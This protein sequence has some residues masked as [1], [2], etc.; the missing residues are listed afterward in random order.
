MK[1]ASDESI[2]KME[3]NLDVLKSLWS[4]YVVKMYAYLRTDQHMYLY[5]DYCEA[6]TLLGYMKDK[7]D[8]LSEN[9]TVR[10]ELLSSLSSGS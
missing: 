5:F 6:G 2:E 1:Y 8:P 7:K 9:E 4:P 10:C 3:A